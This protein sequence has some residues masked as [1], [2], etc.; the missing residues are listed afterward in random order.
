[1]SAQPTQAIHQT[2]P[3]QQ[4]P[5]AQ[6]YRQVLHGLID[7]GADL[8]RLL[9]QQATPPAQAPHQGTEPQPTPPPAQDALLTIT[10]A[11]DRTA[12]AV[13]RCIALAQHL[14]DPV[15]PAND[16]ARHRAAARKR[17]IREVE[18]AIERTAPEGDRAE[19]LNAELHD[20]LD[21]PDLD[22]DLTTRPITE[23]ITEIR[24]D[25][26]LASLPGDHPCKRRTPADIQQLQARAAAP[27]RPRQPCVSPQDPSHGAAQHPPDP[28]PA[29]R[30]TIPQ[31]QPGPIQA[32]NDPPDDP[33]EAIAT[34]L[35]HSTRTH[36]R[37]RPPPESQAS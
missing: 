13:R 14:N 25:L 10:A 19:R 37:W 36:G 3:G 12:R 2:D 9:H 18:D 24:R 20:R 21:A 33:A 29:N 22:D 32:G 5:D 30:T 31:A 23:I 28:Q 34:I 27:S 35:R 8:A 26:G 7:I 6:Y 11:F 4:A 1:M 17:I 16:P 15:Q